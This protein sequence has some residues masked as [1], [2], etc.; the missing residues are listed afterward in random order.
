VS[1][2]RNRQCVLIWTIG[3]GEFHWSS[4]RVQQRPDSEQYVELSIVLTLQWSQ[5]LINFSFHGVANASYRSLKYSINIYWHSCDPHDRN[6]WDCLETGN[7]M[8]DVEQE[9]PSG[10]RCQEKNACTEYINVL[11]VKWRFNVAGDFNDQIRDPRGIVRYCSPGLPRFTGSGGLPM[12]QLFF[13][14]FFLSFRVGTS[15]SM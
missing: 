5:C 3:I 14:L 15:H 2:T 8:F 6:V 9:C 11:T 12:V 4:G 10:V 1:I 13:F 7:G